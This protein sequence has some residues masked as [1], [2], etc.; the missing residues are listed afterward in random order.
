LSAQAASPALLD[1]L[2]ELLRIPS[3]SSGGGDPGQLGRAAA[4]LC[5]RIESAGGSC[6]LVATDRNP[7]V[8]GELRAHRADAPTVLVYGHYDV[9]SP[10]PAAL[11]SSP[12]F[13]PT[14]RDGRLYAR[15]AS[16]D[17]GNFLPLLHV[18]CRLARAGELPVHVRVLVD[19]EEEI[20]GQSVVDWI[21]SDERGA[22][23]GIVFDSGMVDERTPAITISTRGS[24]SLTVDVRTGRADVHS[25]MFGNAVLNAV[26]VLAGMLAAVLP[27]RHGRLRE[28]LR[29]GTVEPGA[30]EVGGWADLPAA[31]GLVNEVGARPHDAGAMAEF[32][33]RTWSE[34]ALDVTGFAGGDAVQTRTIIPAAARAKI[35][36]RLAPDQRCDEMR[37]VLE[38]LL[39]EAA[40]PGAKVEIALAGSAEPSSFD[41]ADP[42]LRL[43]AGALERAC[44]VPPAIIR[45]GG[46][47]PVMAAFADRGIPALLSGFAADTDGAH[48]PNESFSLEGLRL[49]E[50]AAEELYRSLAE[51]R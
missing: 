21:A 18:A 44:G 26:H 32:Y 23:C 14:I 37:A 17:K 20:L 22:D 50:R 4:W 41:P 51:L 30:D 10:E 6:S 19:G 3:I 48:G 15:G 39:R 24:I 29:A 34:P 11:W 28:E 33:R 46:S 13:E 5:E 25:G 9:Q 42:A 40:P 16:D 38:R 12:P 45:S 1:E 35:A 43:C 8:V 2:L 47:L 36:M 7:L 31:D 49:G 27:D